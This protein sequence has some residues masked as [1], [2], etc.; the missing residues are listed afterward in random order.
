MLIAAPKK[1]HDAPIPSDPLYRVLHTREYNAA[2][3]DLRIALGRERHEAAILDTLNDEMPAEVV[4]HGTTAVMSWNE[5]AAIRRELD[6]LSK[7]DV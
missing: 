1:L 5:A 6:R 2:C 7:V 4:R 3:E